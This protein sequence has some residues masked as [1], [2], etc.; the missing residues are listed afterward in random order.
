[1]DTSEVVRLLIAFVLGSL[2]TAV[3]AW[4]NHVF[5]TRTW[6]RDRR[7]SEV[8][9]WRDFSDRYS[10]LLH[11][12]AHVVGLTVAS[13]VPDDSNELLQGQVD[14]LHRLQAETQDLGSGLRRA[15]ESLTSHVR[16]FTHRM[17]RAHAGQPPDQE[18]A[19]FA[20]VQFR[21]ALDEYVRRGKATAPTL[22]S[23]ESW[24]DPPY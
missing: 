12:K 14:E 22:R 13:A 3:G 5:S 8:E 9:Y 7:S 10:G 11:D 24:P 4:I 21:Q 16:L 17:R 15:P 1:M 19:N 2:L 20:L 23:N 6:E 18:F